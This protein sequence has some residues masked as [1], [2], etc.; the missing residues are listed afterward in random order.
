MFVELQI[1]CMMVRIDNFDLSVLYTILFYIILTFLFSNVTQKIISSFQFSPI[2]YFAY[3]PDF[4]GVQKTIF[5]KS[6]FC[7]FFFCQRKHTTAFKKPKS[8][9]VAI[10]LMS[11][12]KMTGLKADFNENLYIY[13]GYGM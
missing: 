2:K 6:D 11:N 3:F 10:S 7:R 12:L 9:S 5:R 4:C 8:D 1:F 13:V